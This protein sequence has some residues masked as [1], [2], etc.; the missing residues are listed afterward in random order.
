M[1]H[2]AVAAGAKSILLAGTGGGNT[3]GAVLDALGD[4]VQAGVVVVQASRVG[5]GAVERNMEVNDDRYGFVAAFDLDTLKA[6]ILIQLLLAN[7]FSDAA[8]I[9]SAFGQP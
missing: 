8:A 2:A 7:G 3:S 4:A 6:R 9:Q 1:T 5:G